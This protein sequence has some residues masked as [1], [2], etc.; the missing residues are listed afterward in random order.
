MSARCQQYLSIL[1]LGLSPSLSL[2]EV[3][4]AIGVEAGSTG[5]GLQLHAGVSDSL[6][7]RLGY[8]YFSGSEGVDADDNNGVEDD[9]LRYDGS[10][11]LNNLSL[12]AD[13][14]PWAGNFHVSAGGVLNNN[15]LK[16]TAECNNPSG[17]EVGEGSFSR[18]EI[19]TITT[20]IDFNSFGPYLGIGWGNPV[21][22]DIGI[23]WNFELGV[24]YQGEP[25]VS[26][27]SD[28][29]CAGFFA[30]CREA[31]NDEAEELEEDL[32]GLQLYPVI[33]LGMS[34]RFR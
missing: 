2:A 23:H 9:E 12:L 17:C 32:S 21:G 25:S 30:V 8:S 1:L 4:L 26:M 10:L 34:Y 33:S 11:K 29:T 22:G 27:T 19:G 15:D 20:D 28:G 14:Y 31:L 3:P 24:V 5:L 18:A 13:W 6:K 7:V 16:V